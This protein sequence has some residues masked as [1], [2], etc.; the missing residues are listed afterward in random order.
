MVLNVEQSTSRGFNPDPSTPPETI[1]AWRYVYNASGDIVGTSDARGCGQNFHYDAAGRLIAEDYSPCQRQHADYTAPNLATGDGTEVFNRYDEVDPDWTTVV[2]ADPTIGTFPNLYKGRL[3]ST[4][5]R[6]QKSLT[7]FDGRGRA[8]GLARRV[9]KPGA[10]EVSLGTRYAP[11]WYAQAATFDGADRPIAETTGVKVQELLG[12]GG[13]SA[14]GTEYSK[15]GTV[16]KVTSSYGD[17]VT[18]IVREADGAMA[19]LVYGD[20]AGTTTDFGYDV[21]RRVATVQTYRG[22]PALWSSPGY[23]PAVDGTTTQLLLEDLDYKYDAVDNPIEIRDWRLQHEWPDGA[24]PVTRKMEYD[25]LYRLTKIQ[26]QHAGGDDKW[27][28]PFHAE[29]EGQ[30]DPRRARPAPHVRFDK[31]V[32]WQ[33]Y[34]YDW[35]GNTTRIDDDARGFY[36]RSLGAITNAGYQLRGATGATSQRDGALS[37]H[38]DD[39]GHLVGLSI[40]RNGPCLPAG[41]TCS[42]RFVY[43]WDEAGRL[44][45]ARRWDLATPGQANEPAPEAPPAVELRYAYDGGDQRV[46]KAALDRYGAPTYTV[47]VFDALELRRAR[48]DDTDYERTAETEVGY[49]YAN[50]VRLARLHFAADDVPLGQS[51]G[52]HVLF[53]LPDHLGSSSVILD[54]ATGELVERGTYQALGSADSDYRPARWESFREDYCF[55]GKEADAELGLL[56]FGKRYLSPPLGRWL[57]ADPLTVHGLGADPNAYAYVRGQALRA[58]DAFGLDDGEVGATMMNER[59]LKEAGATLRRMPGITN[60]ARQAQEQYDRSKLKDH[61]DDAGAWADRTYDKS[62]LKDSLEHPFERGPDNMVRTFKEIGENANP[63]TYSPCECSR[64]PRDA[65]Q[66]PAYQ[67]QNR[68]GAGG[69]GKPQNTPSKAP[70]AKPSAPARGTPAPA[71]TQTPG[72]AQIDPAKFKYMFGEA[73]GRKHSVDRSLQNA[74]QLARI[75]VFDNPEGRALLKSHL[76]GV[77]KD[78]SNV[79]RTLTNEHG[80]FEVRESLFFGPGGALKFESSWQVLEGGTRRLTTVIPM[81][82]Q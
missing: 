53:S 28:S 44:A 22:P 29:N 2:M 45:R 4:S 26:Y 70:P 65:T 66:P 47:Y 33:S 35:L 49:L 58:V 56:Y 11:R 30:S 57:S 71:P 38:Y 50:G 18:T 25:D 20:I 13:A 73:A 27:V 69:G 41:A 76:E 42:M 8:T 31:R 75:G 32:Q 43:D 60:L 5:D 40:Q 15:R 24:K 77:V 9:A 54:K 12:A 74:Q 1:K 17:L 48:W 68:G 61:V 39:A 7:R 34:A 80:V 55:T 52:L 23:F 67:N 63:G 36:D 79:V 78:S 72:R 46:L 62:R 51:G 21:R 19:R 81:G 16:K 64:R 37:A 10:P 82:G 3:A 59:Q 14:V 6:A